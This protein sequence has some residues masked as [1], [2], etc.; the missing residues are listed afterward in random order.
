MTEVFADRHQRGGQATEALAFGDL[1][2]RGV[3]GG[4]RDGA[5]AGLVVH[6]R[7]QQPFRVVTA[8]AR[9]GAVAGG[10]STLA[11]ARGQRTGP[12]LAEF[13]ELPQ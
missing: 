2:A 5:G 3:D 1:G 13:G 7:R 6:L 11:V 8:G 10:L 4:G 9:A 12:W